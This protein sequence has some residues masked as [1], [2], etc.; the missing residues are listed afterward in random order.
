MTV[1][2]QPTDPAW[3]PDVCFYHFPCDDG[4]AAAWTVRK[5]WPDVAL[6]PINYQ[7]PLPEVDLAGKNLLLV[8]FSFKSAQLKEIAAIASTVVVID[9]HKT[10]ATELADFPK[11]D[12]WNPYSVG[13]QLLAHA[14]APRNVVTIFDMDQCGAALTWRFCFPNSEIPLLIQLVEDRDLWRCEL[15]DS[16]RF[17]LYLRSFPYDFEIW[18][19][20][21]DS[22]R[23]GTTVWATMKTSARAIERFYDARVADIV[24]TATLQALA[25]FDGVPVAHAPY[26]FVSDVGHEL[27]KKYPKAPFAG[28]IVNA[29][30]GRTV[31][32]RSDDGRFDVSEIAQKYGGGGHRNAAGFRL[33]P[34]R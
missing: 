1:N 8:D 18:S 31:S 25:G 14:A 27:L 28:V 26:S 12:G 3:K 33:D 4:F 23:H 22:A 17:S 32:L 20:I 7:Q 34:V 11:G 24:Q 16:R 10:A 21:N 29:Y 5:R 19:E 15:P 6:Y 30:G 9:H 2:F 13:L